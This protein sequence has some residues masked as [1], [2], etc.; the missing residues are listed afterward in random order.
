MVPSCVLHPQAETIM[1]HPV[2][3][4]YTNRKLTGNILTFVLIGWWVVVLRCGNYN[5]NSGYKNMIF[6]NNV[7]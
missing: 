7:C 1:K 5:G 6:K 3:S 2:L 4:N